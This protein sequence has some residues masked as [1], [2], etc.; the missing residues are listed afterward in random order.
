MPTV[1]TLIGAALCGNLYW[2]HSPVG[3]PRFESYSNF[4]HG[5]LGEAVQKCARL[6]PVVLSFEISFV[7]EIFP[8]DFENFETLSIEIR[9]N[10]TSTE[11][12]YRELSG[13]AE[14]T[15]KTE[16]SNVATTNIDRAKKRREYLISFSHQ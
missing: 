13:I 11:K 4:A 2:R 5:S 8:G 1:S 7:K 12:S 6:Q 14:L 3:S 15:N 16:R 10:S 9:L